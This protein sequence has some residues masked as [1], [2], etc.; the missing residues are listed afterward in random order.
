VQ[1]RSFTSSFERQR[2]SRLD[3]FVKALKLA[4]YFTLQMGIWLSW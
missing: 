2:A 4:I 1:N 3:D